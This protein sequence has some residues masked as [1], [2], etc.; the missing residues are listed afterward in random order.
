MITMQDIAADLKLSPATVCYAMGDHWKAKGIAAGTRKAILQRSRELGYRRNRIAAGL[1]TRTTHSI[2]LLFPCVSDMYGDLLAGVE[3][4][5]GNDYA[6]LLGISEYQADRERQLL[7]SFEDRMVDGLII[8]NVAKE[9]NASYLNRLN[10]KKLPIVQ[11]DRYFQGP[12]TD[13]VEADGSQL[14]R[15]LT[16]HMLSLGHRRIAYLPSC[17]AFSGSNVRQSGYEAVMAEHGLPSCVWRLRLENP[18][19]WKSPYV[20]EAFAVALDQNELPTAIV[21]HD[22]GMVADCIWA[23]EERGIRC[24]DELSIAGVGREDAVEWNNP[25]LRYKP[26]RALW[27]VREMGLRA[28]K[29]LLERMRSP[30]ESWPEPRWHKIPGRLL[31]GGSTAP[32]P[33]DNTA[34][35]RPLFNKRFVHCFSS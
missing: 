25:L 26:T 29:M 24:P 33:T 21:A 32:P 14:T 4:G 12:R 34:D 23:M 13:I 20:K 3:E 22:D 1:T 16:E 30:K 5:L 17:P 27:A 9:D 15:L 18:S 31:T 10:Q 19:Q 6:V 11:A 2:G 7:E 28:A 35:S 8:V